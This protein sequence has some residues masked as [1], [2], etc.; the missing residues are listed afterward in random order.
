MIDVSKLF[1]SMVFNESVMR[2]RLPKEVYEELDKTIREGKLLDINIKNIVANAMKEWA[3]SKGA[4]HYTHWFQPMVGLTAEKHDSFITKDEKGKIIM[5]FSGDELV[6]GESDA[7]SFPSG[8]LRS[9]F[10]ARG[11]TTWDPTSYA[12]V[13]DDVLYIPT[14][15]CSFNGEVLDKKAP[16]L[17]SMELINKH[18]LR[19]LKLFGNFSVKRVIPTVGAEQEYFLIDRELYK[20]R[21]DLIYCKRTLFGAPP[22][23]GQELE[24]HYFRS[25]SERISSFMKDLDI[26]LWKLGILAKTKHNEVAPSQY[27]LAPVFTSVNLGTDNNQLI[28]ETLKSV[29]VRNN[30][31]CL[32][33]EKPFAGING[34]GKHNNWSLS[35]DTGINLFDPGEEPQENAQ[36]ILF[37]SSVIKAVDNY[38]DLLRASVASAGNDCRLGSCEAPPAII[39]IFLGSELEKILNDLEDGKGSRE[40]EKDYLEIGVSVLPKIKKD[41]TDRNR[42]SPFAFT[43]NKFEFR[44]VGSNLS[45][46]SPNIILNTIVAE[47]LSNFADILENTQNFKSTL[48]MLISETIKNHKRILFNGDNYSSSWEKE[49]KKRGLYELKTSADSLPKLISSKNVKLFLKHKLYTEKEIRSRC[50]ALIQNYCKIINIEAKVMLEM[51]KKEILPSTLKY[52]DFLIKLLNTKE[53]SSTNF[54]TSVEKDIIKT[55]VTLTSRL[56]KEI[57]ILDEFCNPINNLTE[58]GSYFCRDNILP[59]MKNLRVVADEI[60]VNI[61]K[62]FW[63]YPTYGEMLMGY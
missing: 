37:L 12:F 38:Q 49:A 61:A 54:D 33:H 57:K 7:S 18:A 3:I 27:E 11:Y 42:T 8:G 20:K 10:E 6:R 43:G 4:T 2:E 41:N 17:K 14:A 40:S 59:A 35:T 48:K 21:P 16:L 63:P 58:N 24:D 15:F 26:E 34:S 45:I 30:F 60:E 44:M 9:T 25:M 62:E 31:V 50:N 1:G 22:P 52:I 13:K 5:N 23:K 36:F 55:M 28:M 29:A 47:E 56:H 53:T 39:S 51:A 19:I 32:L 46:A